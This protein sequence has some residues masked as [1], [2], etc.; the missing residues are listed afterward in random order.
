MTSK[1]ISNLL[2][3]ALDL[4]GKEDTLEQSAEISAARQ[5][6]SERSKV[7]R[8]IDNE[9]FIS[10]ISNKNPE[11]VSAFMNQISDSS[12][13][14]PKYWK[15]GKKTIP[16]KSSKNMKFTAGSTNQNKALKNR[17]SK[18]ESYSERYAAKRESVSNRG[19]LKKQLKS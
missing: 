3:D 13:D 11:P 12:V 5:L 10:F 6:L 8:G 18:G 14:D 2:E 4:I 7:K 15:S 9:D 16:I 1:S 17:K 19:N